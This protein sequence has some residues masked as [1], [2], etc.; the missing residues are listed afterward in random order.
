[1]T[2]SIPQY[3]P[4]FG[5]PPYNYFG[6]RKV[7][8][9]CRVDSAA[10]S[11]ALPEQLTLESDIIEVFVMDVPDAGSLGSYREGGIVARVRYGEYVG[12]HVLY[13]YVTS[14]DS[15]AAGREIWGYPK[16]LCE[17]DWTET[18]NNVSAHLTRRGNALIDIEFKAGEHDYE[19]P[20]LQPRLQVKRIP[21]ADGQGN[22]ID[23]VILNEL[24][25]GT[26][27][28]RVSGQAEVKLG[29]W[30]QDPLGELKITEIIGAE[31]IVADF[32]LEFGKSLD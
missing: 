23:S 5:R 28:Q 24:K 30:A 14:D 10:L 9:I 19:R 32:V 1:M 4:L 21:S 25:G 2:Y 12:G 22:D 29:S 26:I 27:H 8:A 3:A 6:Y 31:F 13:E 17:I 7:S 20:V 18:G 15:M 16:K 11:A